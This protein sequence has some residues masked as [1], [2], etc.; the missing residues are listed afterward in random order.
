EAERETLKLKKVEYMKEHIGETF[1]GVISG[2][3]K[4]GIY[5]ELDNTIEGLIHVTNMTDDHY[6]YYEERHEMVG[7]HTQKSYKLGE[8]IQVRV[9][10]TDEMNR[11]I[12]FAF[13]E[14]GEE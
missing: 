12:D 11:T 14:E 13:A 4:W 7:N 5:A 1:S 2:I 10:D 9:L 3:T 8:K 6:E